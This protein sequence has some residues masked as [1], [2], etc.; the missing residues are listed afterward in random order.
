MFSYISSLSLLF[1]GTTHSKPLT[2][3]QPVFPSIDDDWTVLSEI[4]PVINDHQMKRFYSF[5]K[6]E[7]KL[8]TDVHLEATGSDFGSFPANSSK[9]EENTQTPSAILCGCHF[10]FQPVKGS[11]FFVIDYNGELWHSINLDEILI[12]I[13]R[14]GNQIYFSQK[15]PMQI[16]IFLSAERYVKD[17]ECLIAYELIDLEIVD[18]KYL[19][20]HINTHNQEIELYRMFRI[21]KNYIQKPRINHIR[22]TPDVSQFSVCFF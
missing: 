8:F 1:T 22:Y 19:H 7:Y 12:E 10:Q 2:T 15:N 6:K 21:A 5:L 16:E 11:A 18:C 4:A 14:C 17:N 9:N 20:K 13:S 3:P